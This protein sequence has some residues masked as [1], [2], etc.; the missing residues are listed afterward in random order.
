[1]FQSIS[2]KLAEDD[3]QSEDLDFIP[4]PKRK[5]QDLSEKTNLIIK[6]GNTAIEKQDHEQYEERDSGLVFK[7]KTN[8]QNVLSNENVSQEKERMCKTDCANTF[9]EIDWETVGIYVSY[10]L[11]LFLSMI[12]KKIVLEIVQIKCL[13]DFFFFF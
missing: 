2:K 11:L 5:K 4:K 7:L 9:S 10:H 13:Y 1:M 12:I 6:V 8:S 3:E